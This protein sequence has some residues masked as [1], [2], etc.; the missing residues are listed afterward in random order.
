MPL[1]PYDTTSSHTPSYPSGHAFQA[2]IWASCIGSHFPAIL[3]K[4]NDFAS[5]VAQSRISL[6]VHYPSDI[7]AGY[8]LCQLFMDNQEFQDMFLKEDFFKKAIASRNKEA[9]NPNP[10]S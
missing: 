4:L 3:D 2:Y 7:D 6:G 10:E 9:V 5:D 8:Y 1:F